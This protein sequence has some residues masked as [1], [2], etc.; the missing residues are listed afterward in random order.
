MVHVVIHPRSSQL[1]S[2]ISTLVSSKFGTGLIC[3]SSDRSLTV[4]RIAQ[5][6]QQTHPHSA[7]LVSD[8]NLCKSAA[9]SVVYITHFLQSIAT[10]NVSSQV[11]SV[12][13]GKADAAAICSCD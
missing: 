2:P 5:Q 7:V 8:C 6:T 4:S 3:G 12:E 11:C 1:S 10:T 9:D 13:T